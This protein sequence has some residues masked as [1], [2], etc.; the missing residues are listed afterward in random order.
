PP[1]P[2]RALALAARHGVPCVHEMGSP[3]IGGRRDFELLLDRADAL[4]VE[5]VGYWGELDFDYVAGRKLSQVGGDLW[6]DGS[7]GA[8]T[9]PLSPPYQDVPRET[10]GL[11][12]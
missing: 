6:L 12:D 3:G 8:R 10:R 4:P 11:Y 9:A 1:P 5:V 7:L 2:D